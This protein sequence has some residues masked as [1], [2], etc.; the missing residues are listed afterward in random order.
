ME[1]NPSVIPMFS[2]DL[3]SSPMNDYLGRNLSSY[4][5]LLLATNSAIKPK[6][7]EMMRKWHAVASIARNL[8]SWNIVSLAL[9]VLKEGRRQT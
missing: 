3:P 4:S 2:K 5:L 1:D 8:A 9:R 7:T 6:S